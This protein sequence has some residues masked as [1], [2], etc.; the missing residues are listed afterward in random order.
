[1]Y[2]QRKQ[3][4]DKE[5]ELTDIS[6]FRGEAETLVIAQDEHAART[7]KLHESRLRVI[8]S[9]TQF[10]QDRGDRALSPVLIFKV[11][12]SALQVLSLASRFEFEWP[13][14]LKQVFVMQSSASGGATY[15]LACFFPNSIPLVSR[16][17]FPNNIIF[18]R[19]LF[20]QVYECSLLMVSPAFH[21]FPSL[22]QVL[23]TDLYA[24]G[25]AFSRHY[26]LEFCIFAADT[27]TAKAF[28]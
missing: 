1:M 7:E 15:A 14:F 20:L 22:I 13:G 16:C 9:A 2:R 26:W 8:A 28:I 5:K 23:A 27:S 24:S 12:F 21:F 17:F 3:R 19:C 4:L 11:F 6:L 25:A 18:E 10:K